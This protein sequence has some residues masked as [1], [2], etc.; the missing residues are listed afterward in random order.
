MWRQETAAAWVALAV[1]RAAAEAEAAAKV[2]VARV[3]APWEGGPFSRLPSSP[4]HDGR[5]PTADPACNKHGSGGY[6]GDADGGAPQQRE[7]RQM[8]VA[9]GTRDWC[10]SPLALLTSGQAARFTYRVAFAL[11]KGKAGRTPLQQLLVDKKHPSC[12]PVVD[13]FIVLSLGKA[14]IWTGPNVSATSRNDA[15][16]PLDAQDVRREYKRLG[17]RA[18]KIEL[19]SA[20]AMHRHFL[21]VREDNAFLEPAAAL[22]AFAN[23]HMR[24]GARSDDSAASADSPTVSSQAS[25]RHARRR[26]GRGG[27]A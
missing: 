22:A 26:G 2:A 11:V 13:A 4:A 21:Y 14:A 20:Q 10:S 9:A 7:A 19:L 12:T 6:T 8:A 16:P 23:E 5:R 27:A 18:V 3:T 15:P 1:V 25:E 24:R 17:V